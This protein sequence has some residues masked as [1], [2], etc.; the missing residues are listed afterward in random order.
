VSR[1]PFR[2]EDIAAADPAVATARAVPAAAIATAGVV[3]VA[4]VL[5]LLRRRRR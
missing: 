5:W 2:D 3:L 1:Q 4:G